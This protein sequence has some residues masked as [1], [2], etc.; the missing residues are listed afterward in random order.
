MTCS[1]SC[2]L[3]LVLAASVCRAQDVG[4]RQRIGG[5]N[6]QENTANQPSGTQSQPATGTTQPE[7]SIPPRRVN[8]TGGLINTHPPDLL[9]QERYVWPE[10]RRDQSDVV[11][12]PAPQVVNLAPVNQ[13][14]ASV[15]YTDRGRGPFTFAVETTG[16]HT[17]NLYNQFQ[18]PVAGEYI[19]LGLPIRMGL[20]SSRMDIGF[21]SRTNFTFYPSNSDV[22]HLS[23]IF[24]ADLN[25]RATALTDWSLSLAGG[26]TT[27][28]GTYL[29]ASIPIG[30][31]NV[32][33]SGMI[34]GLEPS[35]NLAASFG[36]THRFSDTSRIVA[37]LTGAWLQQPLSPRQQGV[38]FYLN[39]DETA[40]VDL[41]FQHA[42]S[43]R[44]AVGVETTY[45]FVRGL[46]PLGHSNYIS[47]KG[48]Y[49]Y[50]LSEHL[51]LDLGVGPL[52]DASSS[53]ALGSDNRW[54][55]TGNA[56]F[57]YQTSFGRIGIGY[58]RI[59]QL[60]YLL[61]S[62]A[63]NQLSAVYDRPLNRYVDF[64]ADARYVQAGSSKKLVSD[65]SNTGFSA[66]FNFNLTPGLVLFAGSSYFGQDGQVGT[67]THHDVSAGL[68]YTFG[69]S[70]AR[71]RVR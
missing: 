13:N 61:A 55:Y 39:R 67:L 45:L 34:N 23:T 71:R 56:G 62:S 30:S 37:S 27:G 17:N 11:A 12:V 19:D 44:T 41:H 42:V 14:A 5:N 49:Q 59:V 28:I 53:H 9:N 46:S 65:Y 48:T 10:E 60:G 20:Q 66:R 32:V 33:Q 22:N 1:L 31:T 64:T 8:E 26:R 3:A 50:A 16:V 52:F 18:N 35:Y 40:G 25:R 51:V 47:V 70:L 29:P 15:P 57:N 6:A 2:G 58:A 63:A 36:L 38:P 54:T 24:T 4:E 68:T 7:R 69:N 21:F 43:P